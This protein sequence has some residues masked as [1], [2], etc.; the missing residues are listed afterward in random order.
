MAVFG[1]VI[2]LRILRWE[3]YLGLSEWALNEITGILGER[4]DMQRRQS[5]EKT[6][7]REIWRHGSWRQEWHSHKQKNARTQWLEEIS[8]R[9]LPRAFAGCI[10]RPTPWIQPSDTH[11]RLLT[12]KFVFFR[13]PPEPLENKIPLFKNHWLCGICYSQETNA[14]PIRG[15]LYWANL[16]MDKSNFGTN[17]E[18]KDNQAILTESIIWAKTILDLITNLLNLRGMTMTN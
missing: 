1:A 13:F 2:K 18:S 16:F 5:H 4:F 14:Q 15:V 17:R 9:F 11:F 12:S 10:T 3:N 7:Q 8:N 6:E